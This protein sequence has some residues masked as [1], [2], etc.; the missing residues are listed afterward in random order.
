MVIAKFACKLLL[1]VMLINKTLF[2]KLNYTTV[3]YQFKIIIRF[4][5]KSFNMTLKQMCYA[6]CDVY[7][8]VST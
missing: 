2:I 6:T 8:N 7:T 4:I 5:I 3:L 1:G